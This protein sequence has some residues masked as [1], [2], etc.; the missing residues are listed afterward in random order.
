MDPTEIPSSGGGPHGPRRTSFN[1]SYSWL[2][3]NMPTQ[4]TRILIIANLRAQHVKV[5]KFSI[6][7]VAACTYNIDI[8]GIFV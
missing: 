2:G 1:L 4:T 3:Q 5:T 6:L 8:A 7:Y